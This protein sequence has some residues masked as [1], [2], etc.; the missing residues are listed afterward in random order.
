M[1]TIS[2]KLNPTVT[3]LLGELRD[4][5]LSTIKLIYQLEIEHLTE[6]QIE[7]VLGDLTASITHLQ[8][9]SAIVKEELDKI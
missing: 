1:L 6:E 8:I 7:D 3:T 5:C 9:H 2:N 4:E